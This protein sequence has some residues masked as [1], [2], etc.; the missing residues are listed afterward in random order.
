MPACQAR[1]GEKAKQKDD[2]GGQE[3]EVA[4]PTWLKSHSKMD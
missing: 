4:H 1:L 3:K 2:H